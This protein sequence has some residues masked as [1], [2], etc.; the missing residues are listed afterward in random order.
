MIFCIRVQEESIKL[1][2]VESS[3]KKISLVNSGNVY[4][5]EIIFNKEECY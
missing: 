4:G 3:F 2:K 5:L 1:G